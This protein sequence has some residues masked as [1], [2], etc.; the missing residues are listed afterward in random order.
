MMVKERGAVT[1]GAREDA[2]CINNV[3][4]P[5]PPSAVKLA[6]SRV[7][8]VFKLTVEKS[9]PDAIVQVGASITREE[10]VALA[11]SYKKV[12]LVA[13]L[14]KKLAHEPVVPPPVEGTVIVWLELLIVGGFGK[15]GIAGGIP[16]IG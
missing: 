15:A 2:A 6:T 4:P 7:T 11:I 14:V 13:D 5:F 10:E 8:F 1:P 16:A 9:I 3:P 12:P